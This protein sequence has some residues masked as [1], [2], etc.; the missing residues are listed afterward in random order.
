MARKR[1]KAAQSPEAK[2]KGNLNYAVQRWDE[3]SAAELR[4]RRE[5]FRERADGIKAASAAQ[6]EAAAVK[7]AQEEA[8]RNAA[9]AAIET[10]Q[11][12][13]VS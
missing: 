6:A 7:A 12:P 8:F 2:A 1:K 11:P 9:L 3:P 13:A 10:G 4:R 5:A